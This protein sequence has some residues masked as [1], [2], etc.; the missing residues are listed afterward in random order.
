VCD[1]FGGSGT[2]AF[3]AATL[4]RR[5]VLSDRISACLLISHGKLALQT[6]GFCRDSKDEIFSY[7][8]WKDHCRSDAIGANGEGA[9]PELSAWYAPGTLAQLRFLWKIVEERRKPVE[10]R[11]LTLV[12]SDVLF[13]CASAGAAYTSTGKRRRH[14]WGWVADNVRPNPLIEHDAISYFESR[15]AAL[16]IEPAKHS[17]RDVV[18]LQQ[19]AKRLALQSNSVDLIVTSPPYVGMIDYTRANRLLYRWMGWPM[20]GE[21]KE[22]IGARFKRGRQGAAAEYLSEMRVCWSE[23]TRVLR[24][25]GYC[26]I[27]IGESRK[28]S[29]VVDETLADLNGMM[30]LVWGPTLRH[31]SRRRVSERDARMPIEFVGVFRK[32]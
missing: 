3:E 12:F 32:T 31:A 30:P 10:R 27:V 14:H 8:T 7:L 15:L 18:I 9:D 25:G 13:A 29:G 2:T 4:G 28:Y 20:E 1:P 23:F 21:R 16:P 6:E 26:A 19:D 11:I 5:A 22:E 24:S 17:R